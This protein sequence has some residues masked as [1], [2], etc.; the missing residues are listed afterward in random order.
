VTV[1]AWYAGPGLT[2][3]RID[4]HLHLLDGQLLDAQSVPIAVADDLELSGV[5]L[6]Q[7][8]VRA[9]KEDPTRAI[10]DYSPSSDIRVS[11]HRPVTG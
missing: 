6:S 2:L 7:S 3:S 10:I 1:A 4:A 11:W 8:A 5:H 9:K